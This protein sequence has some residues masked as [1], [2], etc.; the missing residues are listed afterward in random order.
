MNKSMTNITLEM[1]NAIY[2]CASV[3]AITAALLSACA[4]VLTYMAS[5]VQDRFA[6][7]AIA[8]AN[9]M[10]AEANRAAAHANL[11][12]ESLIKQNIE[13][14]IKLEAEKNERLKTEAALGPRKLDSTISRELVKNLNLC[15]IEPP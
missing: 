11:K 9:Q 2:T 8:N 3:V 5:S 7:Q 14:S 10:S 13:L 12:A 4:G 15:E 1:A 6:D